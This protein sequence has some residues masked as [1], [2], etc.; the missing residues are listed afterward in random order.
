MPAVLAVLVRTNVYAA[1]LNFA[2]ITAT[3]TPAV[4]SA[5]AS[6]FGLVVAE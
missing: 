1:V 6:A 4:L 2:L 5:G 3:K